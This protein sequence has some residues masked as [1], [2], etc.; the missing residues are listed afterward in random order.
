[1][2]LV[3]EVARPTTPLL[4]RSARFGNGGRGAEP[5]DG[6]GDRPGGQPADGRL[7][8]RGRSGR[9]VPGTGIEPVRPDERAADFKSAASA[10]SAI[11][12]PG[13]I[14]DAVG[15][16]SPALSQLNGRPGTT[17]MLVR[18]R[19]SRSLRIDTKEVEP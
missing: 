5:G 19:S 13:F 9:L 17:A 6:D 2:R 15:P 12:A 14:I 1:M 3:A 18:Q 10:C 11:R 16:A 8:A 4:N 7:E